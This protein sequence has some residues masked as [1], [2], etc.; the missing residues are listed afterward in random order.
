MKFL[1]YVLVLLVRRGNI[2]EGH[3]TIHGPGA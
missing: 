2:A 1:H 3:T